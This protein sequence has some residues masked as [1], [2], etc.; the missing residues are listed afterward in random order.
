M[1]RM[2]KQGLSKY[3]IDSSS[4]LQVR[5]GIKGPPNLSAKGVVPPTLSKIIVFCRKSN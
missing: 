2:T 5:I 4:V 1:T 3:L